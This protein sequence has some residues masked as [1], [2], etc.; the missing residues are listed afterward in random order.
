M[1]KYV[2]IYFP[3]VNNRYIWFACSFGGDSNGYVH[4]LFGPI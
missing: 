1:E 3:P 4:P 2:A